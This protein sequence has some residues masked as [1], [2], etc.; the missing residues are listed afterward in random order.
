MARRGKVF[1]RVGGLNPSRSVFDLSH[2]RKFACDF[3]Q[4]IPVLCEMMS[5]GDIFNIRN[6]CVARFEPLLA[7]IM[8]EVNIFTHYFFVPYRILWDRWEDFYTGGEEGVSEDKQPVWDTTNM[9]PGSLWD[10]LIG[11]D[12]YKPTG[13]IKVVDFPRLAYYMIYNEYYR[14]QDLVPEIDLSPGGIINDE[15]PLYR[16][17]T[18]DY[19][20]SMRPWLQKGIPPSLPLT[21]TVP[22]DV[23]TTYANLVTVGAMYSNNF[24]A[25]Q[26]QPT[27]SSGWPWALSFSQNPIATTP[28]VLN[29]SQLANYIQQNAKVDLSKAGGLFLMSDFRNVMQ[30]Q[31][32]ME[33][34]ARAGTRYTEFLKA[35]FGVWPRDE[36]LQRPEYVGG[37]K[38]P[39]I[40]SEVLQTSASGQTGATTDQG[41]LA[42]HGISANSTHI[43][44]YHA[45]EVG[46]I[47]GI[48][49]V[50]PK[51]AYEQGIRRQWLYQTNVEY[52]FAEFAH[53][54]E[55]GVYGMELVCT[56]DPSYDESVIG[57]IPKYDELRVIP[58]TVHSNLKQAQAYDYWH[59]GRQF[60]PSNPPLLNQ[61]FIECNSSDQ[62]PDDPLYFNQLKR[63]FADRKR[64]G[65]IINYA[66]H[67]RALRPIPYLADPG[68]VD[69]F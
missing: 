64:P 14:D 4:L 24:Y 48:L 51:P 57:Y 10:F 56:G 17:W 63:I 45:T 3:G 42:G 28:L 7:P 27:G 12:G 67:I 22:I 58:D 68:L 6:S 30:L 1:A 23:N 36:R 54:S 41:N 35:H 43:G 13:A 52:P 49:S 62:N 34:N 66:N 46:V 20:T 38:Q 11:P 60:D 5:P 33:R 19:F 16:A 15:M 55:Q 47:M 61:E 37:S 44:K 31:K 50:M 26:L 21:G 40:V 69:H 25:S 9:N 39:I 65:I 18:K 53:L 8:H 29:N 59:L 2:E 32:W